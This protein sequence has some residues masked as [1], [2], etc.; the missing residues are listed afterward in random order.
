[1]TKDEIETLLTKVSL[2][3]SILDTDPELVKPSGIIDLLH[4][5]YDAIQEVPIDE[6]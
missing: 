4:E 6:G 1:M 3:I 2:S 5:C